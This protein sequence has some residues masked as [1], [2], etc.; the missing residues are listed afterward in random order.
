M[1][2]KYQKV[3]KFTMLKE[4]IKIMQCAKSERMKIKT[5][6]YHLGEV[7]KT[8]IKESTFKKCWCQVYF[9]LFIFLNI[10]LFL[11]LAACRVFIVACGLQSVWAQKLPCM[12]LVAPRHVRYGPGIEPLSPALEGRF[13]TTGPQEEVPLVSGLKRGLFFFFN[14]WDVTGHCHYMN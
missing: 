11:L 3:N 5:T 7:K 12:G 13:L 6:M 14:W 2:T 4:Y 10:Y 9:I 1:R 8:T